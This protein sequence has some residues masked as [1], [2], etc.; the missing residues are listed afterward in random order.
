MGYAGMLR[1]GHREVPY[2]LYH[3]DLYRMHYMF[4]LSAVSSSCPLLEVLGTIIC[5]TVCAGELEM[6]RSTEN[7]IDYWYTIAFYIVPPLVPPTIVVEQLYLCWSKCTFCLSCWL[8][9]SNSLS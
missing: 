1:F 4:V 8:Q 2:W 5:P 9:G 7:G 3:Q 6:R